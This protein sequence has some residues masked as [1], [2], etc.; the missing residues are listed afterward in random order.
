MSDKALLHQKILA[1]LAADQDLLLQSA[2]AA[3]AEATDEQNK[4]ENKYDTRALE[5]SYLAQGQ[6]RQ[7]LQ[8]AQA[9]QQFEAL[10][11]REFSGG[12]PIGLGALVELQSGPEH[13]F[14]FM[15]PT[16]GGMEIDHCPGPVWVL[17]PHSPL[18]QQ[19]MGRK[20]GDR[21]KTQ[22]GGKSVQSVILGVF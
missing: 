7:A 9:I 16:A 13:G 10:E 14:Y 8:T 3:H 18:G 1:R 20:K 17:T 5:A 6:S 11:V 12:D 4:A 2:R 21:W 15:G 19:L 22:I